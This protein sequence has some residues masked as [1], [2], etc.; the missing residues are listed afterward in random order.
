MRAP[1]SPDSTQLPK[2][3]TKFS[4][5]VWSMRPQHWSI[6]CSS[7]TA[8]SYGCCQDLRDNLFLAV[9]L[10]MRQNAIVSRSIG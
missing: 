9:Q 10:T 6:I 4:R 1:K 2:R 7:E 3:C 5:M 8:L